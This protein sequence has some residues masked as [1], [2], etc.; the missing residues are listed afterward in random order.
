LIYQLDSESKREIPEKEDIV[1]M[2]ALM[3][4]LRD[5]ERWARNL[6]S[7]FPRLFDEEEG[8]EFWPKIESFVKEGNLVVR[9]DMPGI[10]PK[11]VEITVLGNVLTVKGER[12]QEKEIK[13]EDYLRR[14]TSYGAFERRMTLPEGVTPDKIRATF[15]NGVVEVTMPAAKGMEAKKIR[16]ETEQENPEKK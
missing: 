11:D 7:R 6:E 9:A 8:Q 5:L 16:L 3:R 14:E 12:K 2:A 4:P 10:D 15:K 13:K 1:T